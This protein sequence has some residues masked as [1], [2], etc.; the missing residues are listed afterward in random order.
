MATLNATKHLYDNIAEIVLSGQFSKSLK[1]IAL[2]NTYLFNSGSDELTGII[3]SSDWPQAGITLNNVQVTQYNT[4]DSILTS[5]GISFVPFSADIL[6]IKTLVVMDFALTKPLVA[7]VFTSE[8]NIYKST[9]FNL[10][11]PS[12]YIL[13]LMRPT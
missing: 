12:G 4:T 10:S 8:F 1:L 2:N 9:P 6:G 13:K 5:D 11:W 7:F 3:I